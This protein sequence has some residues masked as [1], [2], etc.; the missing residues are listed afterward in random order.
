MSDNSRHLGW[1]LKEVPLYNKI[2]LKA[3]RLCHGRKWRQL[4]GETHNWNTKSVGVRPNSNI[5]GWPIIFFPIPLPI[6][7]PMTS[8]WTRHPGEPWVRFRELIIYSKRVESWV[9]R[10]RAI[11]Y[12]IIWGSG[13]I[14]GGGGVATAKINRHNSIGAL[15]KNE[16]AWKRECVRTE[17][18]LKKGGGELLDAHPELFV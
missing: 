4:A 16:R 6:F 3:T 5:I 17:L 14:G 7:S 1:P 8:Q 2:E 13:W 10:S 18:K 15:Y 11:T 12:G 9:E